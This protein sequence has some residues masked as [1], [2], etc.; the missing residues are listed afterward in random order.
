[1]KNKKVELYNKLFNALIKVDYLFDDDQLE[2]TFNKNWY[3]G[4]H[5]IQIVENTI[6]DIQLFKHSDK[7]DYGLITLEDMENNCKPVYI[8]NELIDQ[9]LDLVFNK[10]A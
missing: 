2:Q 10:E 3:Y 9:I 6:K 7:L 1:M 5:N 8:S 4:K